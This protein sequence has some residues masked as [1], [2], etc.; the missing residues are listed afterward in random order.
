MELSIHEGHS[1]KMIKVP[2]YRKC[3]PSDGHTFRDSRAPT[4]PTAST[5]ER[6][7]TESRPIYCD[8][9][10]FHDLPQSTFRRS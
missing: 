3:T 7:A 10:A 9:E 4:D 6:V 1:I 8:T 2:F 5:W